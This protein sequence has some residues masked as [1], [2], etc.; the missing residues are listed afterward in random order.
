VHD[1]ARTVGIALA[2]TPGRTGL[3]GPSG[4]PVI[5]PA[6]SERL[7]RPSRLSSCRSARVAGDR[8]TGWRSSW[9]TVAPSTPVRWHD[10]HSQ[11]DPQLRCTSAPAVRLARHRRGGGYA[12]AWSQLPGGQADGRRVPGRGRRLCPPLG[13]S[14]R[15]GSTPLGSRPAAG[16][17]GGPLGAN[18]VVTASRVEAGELTASDRRGG[19]S[20]RVRQPGP[21]PRPS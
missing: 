18:S 21:D 7:S 16:A 3:A 1:L 12:E 6:V 15:R 19:A 9:S 10:W 4:S 8:C 2:G 14:W 13:V 17:G 20:A 5:G 11:L